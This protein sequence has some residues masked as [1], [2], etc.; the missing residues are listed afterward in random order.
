MYTLSWCALFEAPYTPEVAIGRFKQLLSCHLKTTVGNIATV[1]YCLPVIRLTTA[2]DLLILMQMCDTRTVCFQ[3]HSFKLQSH[4]FSLAKVWCSNPMMAFLFRLFFF[5]FCHLP[6]TP[7]FSLGFLLSDIV[8]S[9]SFFFPL[10]N[11]Q[12]FEPLHQPGLLQ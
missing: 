7:L 10:W 5:L 11:L 6:F 9:F 8:I 2:P 4:T 12:L 1:L 3:S